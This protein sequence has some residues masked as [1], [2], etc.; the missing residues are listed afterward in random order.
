VD[1]P[2]DTVIRPARP[3]DGAGL[4]RIWLEN[5][6]YYVERFPDDF[7]IPD[8]DGLAA[9]FDTPI[10]SDDAVTLV[11]LVDGEIA[12]F[13]HARIAQPDEHARFQYLAPSVETRGYVE[14]LGTAD[15]YQ[16]RGLATRLV[17]ACE[18]WARDL[19][20]SQ[21]GAATYLDSEVSIPFWER[22]MATTGAASTWSS[23]SAEA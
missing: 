2:G 6:R 11:A 20:A 9:F 7:R 10:E 12:S 8:E 15:A 22:R 3:G 5:A 21:M 19:G 16:G 14:A 23:A 17:E 4:A 18:A 1:A 13:A